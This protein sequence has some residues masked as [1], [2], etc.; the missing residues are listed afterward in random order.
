[1]NREPPVTDVEWQVVEDPVDPDFPMQ[2]VRHTTP[3]LWEAVVFLAYVGGCSSVA[4]SHEEA[5]IRALAAFSAGLVVPY[6]RWISQ[7][8]QKV[9]ASEAQ[10]LRQRLLRPGH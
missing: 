1:M 8:G 3:K 5:A 10:Q 4:Y 6:Y 9:S 7:I 2:V